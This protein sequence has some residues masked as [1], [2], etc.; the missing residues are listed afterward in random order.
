MYQ[1]QMWMAAVRSAGKDYP[2]NIS[3]EKDDVIMDARMNTRV[4]VQRAS[5]EV[6]NLYFSEQYQAAL[7]KVRGLFDLTQNLPQDL[8]KYEEVFSH[9]DLVE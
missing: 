5:R 8:L 2:V 6:V 4:A 7:T 9:S 1:N 3:P